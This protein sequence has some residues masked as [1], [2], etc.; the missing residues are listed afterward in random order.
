MGEIMQLL[1]GAPEME[2]PIAIGVQSLIN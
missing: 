1:P 2:E